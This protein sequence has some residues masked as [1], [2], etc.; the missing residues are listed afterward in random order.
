MIT[1]VLFIGL[2]GIGQRHLRNIL[3]LRPDIQIYALRQRRE[4]IVLD[5]KLHC[6]EGETLESKYNIHT[7]TTIKE[8][9]KP[10]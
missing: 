3:K 9:E 7:V 2:G 8:A 6:I 10:V 1:K 5:D 4:Q